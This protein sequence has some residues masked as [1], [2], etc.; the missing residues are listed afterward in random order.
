MLDHRKTTTAR[1]GYQGARAT[2]LLPGRQFAHRKRLKEFGSN[3]RRRSL[4]L[5]CRTQSVPAYPTEFAVQHAYLALSETR[6]HSRTVNANC[7]DSMS[8]RGT[9]VYEQ[10]D[11]ALPSNTLCFRKAQREQNRCSER[12][13]QPDCSAKVRSSGVYFYRGPR[14]QLCFARTQMNSDVLWTVQKILEQLFDV[15]PHSVSLETK[16][17]DIPQ[18]DS[19]GHLSLCGALEEVFEIRFEVN[20]MAEMTSVRTIVSVIEARKAP[21]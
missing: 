10:T 18:W 12:D 7:I 8:C 20:E 17:S 3:T 16:A 14:R 5:R 11:S 4:D 9:G 2:E 19:V 1:H 15:D 21:N 6:T 13:A